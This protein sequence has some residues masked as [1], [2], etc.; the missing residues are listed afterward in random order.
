MRLVPALARL[1][2]TILNDRRG[3]SA[4]EYGLI[5]ALMVL[6]MFV[7][8]RSLADVTIGLWTFVTREVLAHA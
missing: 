4:V 6:M 8:L 5:L 1:L 3:A 7:G 2:A